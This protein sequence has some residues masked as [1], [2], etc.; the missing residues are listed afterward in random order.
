[1]GPYFLFPQVQNEL[2]VSH[3]YKSRNLKET[4]FS[5]QSS[6]LLELEYEQVSGFDLDA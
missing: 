3:N 2:S 1:M 5:V 4:E 6:S